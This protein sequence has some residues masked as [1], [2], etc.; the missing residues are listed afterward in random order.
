MTNQA[1]SLPVEAGS[2]S[3][4]QLAFVVCP[5]Y[6]GATLL[7]MLLNNHPEVLALG[8]TVPTRS[9]DAGCA[10]GK[11]VSECAFWQKGLAAARV[12]RF[13]AEA[14][15]LPSLPRLVAGERANLLA[16]VVVLALA[17][18]IGWLRRRVLALRPVADYFDAY[19]AFHRA[20]LD[21]AGARIFVDGQKHWL[22]P[23]VFRILGGRD[24][25]VLHLTRD[26]RG[27]AYSMTRRNR[28]D[29]VR[30][31]RGWRR[32]HGVI[33]M[34]GRLAG[35]CLLVRYED[36]A[37]DPRRTT[38]RIFAFLGVEDRDV[39]HGP[40]D[41]ARHH[42]I[43]NRMKTAFDGRVEIDVRWREAFD[44]RE[45]ERISGAAAPL[46]ARFGYAEP[47]GAGA[48]QA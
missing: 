41:P 11:H 14:S 24:V 1:R 30:A 45:L 42:T 22:T 13:A 4:P 40:D 36:L 48:E 17:S 43:G 3:N 32:N 31:A 44:A 26:P 37:L 2:S 35:R 29:A 10:C 28:G 7:S 12:E 20:L 8:D 15:F 34:A 9:Y 33:G 25:S 21:E 39:V 47:A 16:N 19:G 27:F 18:Q 23:L 6:H 38:A 5:S 46:M